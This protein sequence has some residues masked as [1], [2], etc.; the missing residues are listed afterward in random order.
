LRQQHKIKNEVD[1]INALDKFRKMHESEI[2]EEFFNP[3]QTADEMVK[4]FRRSMIDWAEKKFDDLSRAE[5]INKL[6]ISEKT[7]Y[8]WKNKI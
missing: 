1:L 6:S 7:Y 4:N 3:N 8:N 2:N 5:I